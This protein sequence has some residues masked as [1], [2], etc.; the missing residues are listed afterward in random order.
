MKKLDAQK[1][2]N[3]YRRALEEANPKSINKSVIAIALLL[4]ALASVIIGIIVLNGYDDKVMSVIM[5]A[6]SVCLTF[7]AVCKIE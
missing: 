1:Q 2:E 3:A 4:A 6:V 5:L 7:I